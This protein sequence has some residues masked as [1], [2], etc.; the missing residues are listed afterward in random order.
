MGFPAEGAAQ[1]S[2][3]EEK[4]TVEA[5]QVDRE[6]TLEAVITGYSGIGGE[7]DGIRNPTLQAKK[8]E[9][10]Q[11]TIINGETLTH[12]IALERMDVQS[13]SIIE[14]GASTS[15]TFV[16]ES[17]DTY[18]C[19]IPG[20]RAAGM[21]GR[22]EIISSSTGETVA[23]GVIPQ[24]GG[25]PVNLDFEYANLDDWSAEGEAFAGQPVLDRSTQIYG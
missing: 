22:F 5:E 9:T 1:T 13:E 6:Y 3:S 17:G 16:A 23:E 14:E 25:E 2:P 15:V 7:I 21:E 4:Q 10:V 20:H 19:T 12:D 11:I 18:Y 8:G 24:K